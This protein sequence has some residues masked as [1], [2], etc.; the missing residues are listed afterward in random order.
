[1]SRPAASRRAEAAGSSDLEE[2]ASDGELIRRVLDG[3]LEA[4]AILVGRYERAAVGLA[5]SF[6][7]NFEDARELSQNGFVKAYQA[8]G[9][10]QGRAKFSTW[11][12]RI[13]ANECKDFF[14]AKARRPNWVSMHA[15]SDDEE[16]VVFEVEDPS[17]DPRRVLAQRELATVLQA[18]I[19]TLRGNQHE[20]FVLHH[21]NGLPI[22]DVAAVMGCRAGTVKAHLFRACERLRERMARYVTEAEA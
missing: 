15:E 12:Y 13:I 7:G 10:F 22:E 3:Q 8:L 9:R 11:L 5:Y 20:A 18:A 6:V 16:R 21:L 1:M 4:Y 14:R 19:Q 2:T 17:G